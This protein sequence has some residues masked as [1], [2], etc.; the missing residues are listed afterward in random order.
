MYIQSVTS[1]LSSIEYISHTSHPIKMIKGILIQRKS[2]EDA[3]YTKQLKMEHADLVAE[4][5]TVESLPTHE[6]LQLARL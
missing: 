6:R 2:Q 3:S 5:Q 4:M 1:S